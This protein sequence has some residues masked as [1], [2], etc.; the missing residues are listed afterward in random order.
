MPVSPSWHLLRSLRLGRVTFQKDVAWL[1]GSYSMAVRPLEEQRRVQ[2][3]E[4]INQSYSMILIEIFVG[5]NL[6]GG[7][8]GF[9]Y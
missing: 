7:I 8:R 3:I 5:P 2:K 1:T 4:N 9:L 6:L